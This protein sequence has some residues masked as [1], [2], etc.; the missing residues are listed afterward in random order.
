MNKTAFGNGDPK[1]PVNDARRKLQT[2]VLS[3]KA[4]PESQRVKKR[5]TVAH[6]DS[7]G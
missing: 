4:S 2:T 3:E 5:W 6:R 1:I 7:C